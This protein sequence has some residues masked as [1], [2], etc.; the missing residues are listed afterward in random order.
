[1]A[2]S[3]EDPVAFADFYDALSPKVLRFFARKTWDGQVSLELAAE[4]FAKAFEKRGDFRGGSDEQAA[5]WLWA[6]A[7]NELGA[8]WRERAVRLTAVN[9]LGLHAPRA[10]DEEILRVEELAVAEAARGELEIA[11]KT[12]NPAQR[13][14]IG[15][16]ILEE[17]GYEEIALH[18]GVS[19]QVVR[20]RISR[21]LKSLRQFEALRESV[22]D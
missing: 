16:R 10:S 14:V 17:R 5:G 4:T 20:T 18:L 6:I 7:R 21:A 1:L 3:R 2:R 11:L 8:Y 15:M 22:G 12:L 9:Q 19:N 13:E